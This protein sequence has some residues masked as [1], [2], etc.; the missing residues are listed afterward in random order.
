M[1]SP[2][3]RGWNFVRSRAG[4]CPAFFELRHYAR[5]DAVAA[6]S[7]ESEC[8]AV[9]EIDFLRERLAQKA[10]CAEETRALGRLRDAERSG[11]LLDGELLQLAQHEH[12]PKRVCQIVDFRFM[13]LRRL[14][15]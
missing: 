12:G 13:L 10:P 4:T 9:G 1:V 15:A 14:R 7:G 5:D 8:V 11:G 3:G 6:R 2:I